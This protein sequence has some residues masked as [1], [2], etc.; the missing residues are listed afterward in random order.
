[1]HQQV[2][3]QLRD[4]R[5]IL[6]ISA[7]SP[8]HPLSCTPAASSRSPAPD[9]V[10]TKDAHPAAAGPA[11]R[12]C[13]SDLFEIIGDRIEN[14][15][16][17]VDPALP[18]L[19]PNRRSKRLCGIISGGSARSYPPSSCCDGCSRRAI[20]GK[21]RPGATGTE[22]LPADFRRDH[23]VDRGTTG[24]ASGK[25][26][27]RNQAAHRTMMIVARTRLARGRIIQSGDDLNVSHGRRQADSRHGV[28]S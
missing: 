10:P 26:S 17:P 9:R 3:L 6:D 12:A 11:F 27:T 21:R 13:R 23:L 8:A 15:F 25:G 5:V 28:S 14:A 2:T 24:A 4:V 18:L 22:W 20:P 16:L 19:S 1:M 7:Q